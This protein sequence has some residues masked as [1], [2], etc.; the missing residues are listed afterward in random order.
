[1]ILLLL[2]CFINLQAETDTIPST[3]E[4]IHTDTIVQI[5]IRYIRAANDKMIERVYLKKTIVAK[6]S[7][8]VLKDE[9]IANQD[10][11]ISM[12]AD[13]VIK[14][15]AINNDLQEKYRKERNKS[16]IYGSVA[17]GLLLGLT[18][19]IVSVVCINNGK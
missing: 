10:S 3:G 1:M 13:N 12:L 5:P 8:I 11:V 6:D 15:N 14:V 18:A 17:G 4:E 19:T 9:Y 2:S 7:I 16:I